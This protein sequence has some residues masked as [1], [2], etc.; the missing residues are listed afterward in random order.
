MVLLMACSVNDARLVARAIDSKDI[1]TLTEAKA[2]QYIRNSKILVRH[3]KTITELL[4]R[5]K[6]QAQNK[7]VRER[8]EPLSPHTYIT[9]TDG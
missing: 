3:I 2:H 6:S 8:A 7:W 5:P 1:R 4:A 9:Y